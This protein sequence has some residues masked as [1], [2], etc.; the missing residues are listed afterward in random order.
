MIKVKNQKGF[1]AFEIILVVV[2]VLAIGAA[3]YY[4]YDARH[5][6]N[7][8]S[9]SVPEGQSKKNQQVKLATYSSKTD[10]FSF[11][12]PEKWKLSSNTEAVDGLSE[13]SEKVVITSPTGL[14]VMFTTGNGGIGG[15]CAIS[16]EQLQ[17]GLSYCPNVETFGVEKL[18]PF[19]NYQ[20]YL[21]DQHIE[22]EE[23]SVIN[24]FQMGLFSTHDG[25]PAIG[26]QRAFGPIYL[27]PSKTN[28]DIKI[29]NE[30]AYPASSEQ[31]KLTGKEFYA[32]PDVQEARKIFK[33]FRFR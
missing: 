30:A 12:Y 7:D 21:L 22:S 33:S 16:E 23:P 4:A 15:A 5:N 11:N 13:K 14:I 20:L 26:K 8:S 31:N 18:S 9:V 32:L 25:P 29:Q 28:S 3:G 10:T 27:I 24:R 19:G 6:S 1:A 17:S 2:V